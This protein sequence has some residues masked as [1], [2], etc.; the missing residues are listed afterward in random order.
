MTLTREG[1]GEV[2][3]L[4]RQYVDVVGVGGF[5][6]GDM[7]WA[8]HQLMQFSFWKVFLSTP[9]PPFIFAKWHQ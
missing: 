4:S 1:P 5:F 6:D 3:G 9:N 2:L 7:E 8:D